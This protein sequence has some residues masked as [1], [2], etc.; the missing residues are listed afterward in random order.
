[1]EKAVEAIV[2]SCHGRRQVLTLQ[3][4]PDRSFDYLLLV[5]V[6]IRH[7]SNGHG[8]D[9]MHCSSVCSQGCDRNST[10]DQP[11]DNYLVRG[12]SFSIMGVKGHCDFMQGTDSSWGSNALAK[13]LRQGIGCLEVDIVQ[14]AVI[15]DEGIEDEC[16]DVFL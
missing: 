13:D 3:D 1:M 16:P 4:C 5:S 11:L 6:E 7:C 9:L 8:R 2:E 14:I 10:L 12:E 15:N